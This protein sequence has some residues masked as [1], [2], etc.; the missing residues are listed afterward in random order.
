VIGIDAVRSGAGADA[1]GQSRIRASAS[2]RVLSLVKLQDDDIAP[3]L[4]FIVL[5]A[6][7][8][9]TPVKNDTWWLLRSGQ[10]MWQTGRFLVAETFSHT[11]FGNSLSNHWWLTQ[12]AF[13]AVHSMGGPFALTVFAGACALAAT[14]GAWRLMRGA[15]EVR[16][17]LLG[18][19]VLVSTP[20]WGIRPQVISL[21]FVALMAHLIAR[22]KL[23]WLPLV[24]AIW[25]NAHAL[26]IMGV[27][28]TG[29]LVLESLIWPRAHM[30]RA[31]LI[32]MV[33]A[34]APV[35]SPVGIN[36]WGQVIRTVSISKALAIEEYRMPLELSALPFCV[37]VV[38]L[39]GLV[40]IRWKAVAEM[41]RS[42]RTLIVASL[43]LAV[44]GAAAGRNA[45]LFA[46]VG[47][48]AISWLLPAA[49]DGP[50]RPTRPASPGGYVLVVLAVA[51]AGIW[52]A[53]RWQSERM[54]EEWRPVS[55]AAIEAVRACPEPMFNRF[56]DGGYLMWVVPERRV[57]VDS[58]I[59]AYPLDLLRQSRAA[60]VL[61]VYDEP[62]N[63]YGIKC[64]VVGTGSRMDERLRADTRFARVYS[65]ASRSV[66]AI[67][68]PASRP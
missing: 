10:E 19:L 1:T 21:A 49:W 26:V 8:C 50:K 18:W 60:D 27:A 29:A 56:D 44:A 16:L 17:A 35:L 32:T 65:D 33:C 45:S 28:M 38:A 63:R 36:Y 3:L 67:R 40:V 25:A 24:C 61:G 42:E 58:R 30:K 62:F 12:L 51:L 43:V 59:E 34:A 41:S 48:P 6:F 14:F 4:I 57:F 68:S 9:V 46:I 22:D 39:V 7:A 20:G 64:A 15:W 53:Q 37:G 2:S 54:S 55:N 47:A 23:R 66:F 52:V 13:F 5:A 11:A 31:V